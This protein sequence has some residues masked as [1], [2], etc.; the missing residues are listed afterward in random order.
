MSPRK[1]VM[2]IWKKH[3]A[4]PW[5]EGHRRCSAGSFA[6]TGLQIT[7]AVDFRKPKQRL[8]S[9]IYLEPTMMLED[10]LMDGAVRAELKKH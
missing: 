5:P 9:E 6:C 7:K 10:V 4:V 2:Q 1:E 3:L 8:C